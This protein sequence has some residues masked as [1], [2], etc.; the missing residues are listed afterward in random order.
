MISGSIQIK[1][2]KIYIVSYSSRSNFSVEDDN[3]V[4]VFYNEIDAYKDIRERIE[5]VLKNPKAADD[6]LDEADAQINSLVEYP[7]RCK[8]VDDPVLN[9]WGIRYIIV[10]N[11]LAFFIIDEE[12][13]EVIIVRFLFQ[14][15]NWNS[16]LRQGIALY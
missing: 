5:F 15:S 9:S 10:K 1:R 7:E 2:N 8:V 14:K 13:K 4:E 11:Y 12:K 6:L 3:T 16:I